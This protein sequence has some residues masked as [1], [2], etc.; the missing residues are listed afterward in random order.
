[1]NVPT[2]ESLAAQNLTQLESSL[3]QTSPLQR[4]A[5]LR[6]LAVLEALLATGEYKF[7]VD[8]AK[9]NLA[10]TAGVDGL[11]VLG[12]EFDVPR[13]AAVAAV[14]VATVPSASGTVTGASAFIGQPNGLQYYPDAS[15]SA[16]AGVIT[17]TLHC[18]TP[19]AAGNL[20]P[21]AK[22]NIVSPL[23]GV[24]TQATVASVAVTGAEI[25]DLEVWRQRILFAERAT[26]G[27]SNATDYKIW[28][29]E[30]AGVTRAFPFAG[31]PVGGGPSYPGDRTVYV[32]ADVSID[33][34]G[35]PT[36]SLLNSVRAALEIDPLTG[37]SRPVL[38]L[39]DATLY[40]QPIIRTTF[41]VTIT[42]LIT[43]AGQGAAVKGVIA[44]DLATYFAALFSYVEGVDLP[45]YRNDEVTTLTLSKAVQDT[46]EREGSSADL[47]AF[48]V[49]GTSYNSYILAPGELAKGTIAY[50][51]V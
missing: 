10:I 29:E 6:V 28:A 42:N 49:S 24:S 3:S 7:A 40:V 8:R 48:K 36:T 38:G 34:D 11:T 18:T 51:T 20:A 12:Q 15:A 47:V 32:Q 31:K 46:L 4:K 25:E 27:G 14:V 13:K 5:F 22:L 30:V 43:P 21:G 35:V 17:L 45:Q 41:A 16:I 39:T 44:T 26:P 19:G 1:M 33:A 37:L 9:Q 2:T 50:V 23:G